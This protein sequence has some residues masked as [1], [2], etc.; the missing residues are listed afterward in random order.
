M[1]IEDFTSVYC[2]SPDVFLNSKCLFVEF[3]DMI[4][5]PWYNIL[6]FSATSEQMH[7]IY[8]FNEFDPTDG[9][10]CLEWYINRKHKNVFRSL[11][12]HHNRNFP[13]DFH[14]N[15]LSSVELL[16]EVIFLSA[17]TLSMHNVI[18]SLIKNEKGDLI[19]KPIVDKIIIYSER[20]N[21]FIKKFMDKLYGTPSYLS[22]EYGDLKDILKNV[23]RDTTYA[24]SDIDHIHDLYK[25][26]K[27]Q[28]SSILVP[29]NYRYN[30]DDEYN[31]KGDINTLR[32]GNIFKFNL[33]DVFQG[34]N[35]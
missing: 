14:E 29:G 4:A 26:E 7:E 18:N 8:T 11:T 33:I 10:E 9:G 20:E 17:P 34:A 27:L 1:P 24:F 5:I 12:T 6:R 13:P 35:L 31:L 32:E 28:Y 3:M 23:P 2:T 30:F 25:A 15:A 22:Y 21:S 19:T 16:D